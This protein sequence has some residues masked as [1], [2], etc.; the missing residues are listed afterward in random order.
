MWE[1]IQNVKSLF[2][3]GLPRLC[4]E[5][6]SIWKSKLIVNKSLDIVW[7]YC[8]EFVARYLH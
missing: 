6:Q 5:K 8:W 3:K 1:K 2:W 4:N 7:I